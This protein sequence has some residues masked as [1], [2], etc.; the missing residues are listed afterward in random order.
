MKQAGKTVVLL[1]QVPIN[2]NLDACNW[3]PL[4]FRLFNVEKQCEFDEEFIAQWQQPSRDFVDEFCEEFGLYSFDPFNALTSPRQK[5]MNL[6]LDK[7][8]LNTDGAHYLVPFFES[9]MNRIVEE[10]STSPASGR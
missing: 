1:N 9:S 6:Y 7:D 10:E 2:N 5:G 3:R 8:H 4:L